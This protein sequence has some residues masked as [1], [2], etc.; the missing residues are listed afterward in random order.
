MINTKTVQFKL[1][2]AIAAISSVSEQDVRAS[3]TVTG[4]WP[5]DCRF[6][7]LSNDNGRCTDETSVGYAGV[8][9]SDADVVRE[10][11]N[12][13]GDE[14]IHPS[15]RT[16]K[17]LK[18]LTEQRTTAAIIEELKQSRV[19][20][21][22]QSTKCSCSFDDIKK[23]KR[24]SRLRS[25]RTAGDPAAHLTY[26]EAKKELEIRRG[27][28]RQALESRKRKA[29]ELESKKNIVAAER[30]MK[31]QKVA[32]AREEKK[33]RRDAT[34][35]AKAKAKGSKADSLAAE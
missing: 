20:G 14:T 16:Q 4:I 28:K 25:G 2:C 5:L 12:V 7:N 33:K 17:V 13:L 1:I 31:K 34:R 19:S 24:G 27:I 29:E 23:V 10:G 15:V 11:L 30:A 22:N 6:V 32:F 21:D 8:R 18:L 26:G 3:F 9:R 35:E